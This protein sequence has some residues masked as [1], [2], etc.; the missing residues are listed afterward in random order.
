MN[1]RDILLTIAARRKALRMPLS[2]LSR[3]ASTSRPTLCRL[4]TGELKT[5]RHDRLV[6]LLHATGI[7]LRTDENGEC[8]LD[9]IPADEF[10]SRQARRQAEY[11][12]RLTQGTMALEAQAVGQDVILRL[13]DDTS[14]KL[15]AG[16]KS[17]L[18]ED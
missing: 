13:V 9:S 18:W 8:H 16:P 10:V 1:T 5:V 17:D 11:I 3:R 6:K 12:V 2:A 14:R 15:L 7:L 4:L